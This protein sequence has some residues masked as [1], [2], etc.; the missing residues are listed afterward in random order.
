MSYPETEKAIDI[1]NKLHHPTEG[2]P[3]DLKQ[4]HKS[5]LPYLLEETYEFIEAVEN[6]DTRLME[7]EVGD[8]LLQVLHHCSMA[9][10]NGTF[11][12]ESVSKKLS[13]KMIRRHPHVF[14]EGKRGMN[15][16][17][18]AQKWQ[19]L[20]Q[21]EKKNLKK[22]SFDKKFLYAPALEGAYNIGKQSTNVHFDWSDYHQVLSKVEEEWQEVKEELP[23]GTNYNLKRVKEEIGDLL[24]SIAQLA[25]HLN[26][27]PED[28]LKEANKKFINRFQRVEDEIFKSGRDISQT[29]QEELEKLWIEV[30]QNEM[31]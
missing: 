2:C 14:G 5:L 9:H 29:D 20:K 12:I 24:F 27:N 18:V 11:N 7:E 16:D 13:E 4:S 22:Y 17:E 31:S 25:R 8:V 3:W 1:I 23:P 10:K 28:C 21:E 26:L 15:S 30:K 19:E 6:G